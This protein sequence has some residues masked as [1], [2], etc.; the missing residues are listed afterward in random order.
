MA[1]LSI[2]KYLNRLLYFSAQFTETT[3]VKPY[4]VYDGS[5]NVLTASGYVPA[6]SINNEIFSQIPVNRIEAVI[7]VDHNTIPYTP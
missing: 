1:N 2:Q 7:I 4:F 5:G 3:R 6:T